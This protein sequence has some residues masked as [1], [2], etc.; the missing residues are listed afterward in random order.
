MRQ[1]R[2]RHH[3]RRLASQEAFSL[4]VTLR[5]PLTSC[6]L[7]ATRPPKINKPDR[8]SHPSNAGTCLP[9]RTTG[10]ATAVVDSAPP[11]GT[12][13][14]LPTLPRAGSS[15]R[16]SCR[17]EKGGREAAAAWMLLSAG[18]SFFV[19]C[20]TNEHHRCYHD[21]RSGGGRAAHTSEDLIA[22][23]SNIPSPSTQ[24]TGIESTH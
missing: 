14:T 6:R 2:H 23:P 11:L 24:E 13:P 20:G 9:Q 17:G 16:P 21:I 18:G 8:P 19:C 3:R 22:N 7:P 15:V 1:V 4:C 10:D 5:M 12:Y